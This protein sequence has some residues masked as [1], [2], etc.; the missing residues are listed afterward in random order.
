MGKSSENGKN[1]RWETDNGRR[2]TDNG[3]REMGEMDN[4]RGENQGTV[5][6]L[7]A[8][9]SKNR[10]TGNGDMDIIFFISYQKRKYNTSAKNIIFIL[11]F[12]VIVGMQPRPGGRKRVQSTLFGFLCRRHNG[13]WTSLKN[14]GEQVFPITT[15]SRG[16]RLRPCGFA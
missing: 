6:Q 12:T 13:C 9:E 5:P 10:Q 2:E 7:K 3:G 15:C 8:G 1:R 16:L 4:G 14:K 11:K